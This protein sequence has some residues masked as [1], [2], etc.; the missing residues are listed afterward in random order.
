MSNGEEEKTLLPQIAFDAADDH[1]GVGVAKV[2]RNNA[3]GVGALNAQRT[4]QVI[5]A[6]VKL[7]RGGENSRL[8]VFRH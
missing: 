2:A 7:A 4:R 8:G 5:G 1:S 3:D 6:I